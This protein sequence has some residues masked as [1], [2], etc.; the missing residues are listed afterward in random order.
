MAGEYMERNRPQNAADVPESARRSITAEIFSNRLHG[1][2]DRTISQGTFGPQ[3]ERVLAHPESRRRIA[4]LTREVVLEDKP[5]MRLL[6][7]PR[8]G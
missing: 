7:P 2:L 6:E 5:A 4:Q 1:L 3:I 8:A